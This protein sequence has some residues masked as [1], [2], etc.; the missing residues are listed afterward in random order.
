MVITTL[1]QSTNLIVGE[2]T[3][4]NRRYQFIIPREASGADPRG[5]LYHLN[6]RA[7][8][9]YVLLRRESS[10]SKTG[11]R[12]LLNWFI[13]ELTP[14]IRAIGVEDR[15]R[16]YQCCSRLDPTAS[17]GHLSVHASSDDQPVQFPISADATPVGG[18]RE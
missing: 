9:I 4:D 5:R 12:L 17:H 18:R 11:Q 3:D 10:Q 1:V 6:N 7:T 2:L 13:Y 8:G 15:G 14:V 16:L